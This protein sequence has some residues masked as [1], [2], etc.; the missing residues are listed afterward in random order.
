MESRVKGVVSA[1]ETG[2]D[3]VLM[4]G[5]KGMGGAGKTTLARA[6]FDHISIQFDGQS[7]VENVREVSKASLSG[8]KKLQKQVLSDVLNEKG[9]KVSNVHEGKKMMKNKMRARKVLVVLDDVDNIEQ[10]E[11]LAGE[12]N[13]FKPGSRI[14]ITTRDEQVLVSHRVYLIRD[15]NLLLDDEAVCLFSRYAFGKEIPIQGYEELSRQVVGYASGLPLTI[16]VLG[17]FLCGKDEPEWEDAIDRLKTIPLRETLEKLELSYISLEEDY[18]EIFLDV[19]C[20]LKGWRKDKA[21]EVL[22]S[23]GFHARN[24]L[25]V[26][27]QKS[28]ITTKYGYL[29]MHDHIEEMGKNIVRRLHPSEPSRHSRLWIQEEIADILANDLGTEATRCITLKMTTKNFCVETFIKGLGKMKNLRVLDMDM[30]GSGD[31]RE[32][33]MVMYGSGYGTNAREVPGLCLPNALR[34]FRWDLYPFESLMKSFQEDHLV[35]LFLFECE[36]KQF[37]NC[38]ERKVELSYALTSLMIPNIETIS[39]KE[40]YSFGEL[41]MPFEC[42]KLKTINLEYCSELR[43]LKLAPTPNLETLILAGCHNLLEL[44]T[45]FRCPKLK[46]LDLS[47]CEILRTLK[48]APTP[49]LEKFILAGCHNLLE[50]H[51][52][53]RCPKL[54]AL[55][56]NCSKLWTLEF[57]PTLDI[58]TL[59]IQEPD[60][61]ELHMPNECPN[62][63]SLSVNSSKLR[64]LKLG[65]TP[66]LETL[67]LVRCP[68]LTE[69]H[70]PF[71]CPKLKA[72]NLNC[73]KLRTLE[74]CPTLDIETLSIQEPDLLELHMPN[75][76]SLKSLNVNYSKLRTLNLGSAPDLETLSLEG[77]HSLLELHIPICCPK[78]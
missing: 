14:I 31:P 53:F 54:K 40:C 27:E 1:L 78:L 55:D 57:C 69:V 5:I 23:C 25:R 65:S 59:S 10:L 77:C 66:N 8:L 61:L 74:F 16:R 2:S 64:T 21:V 3:D 49:N 38:G 76:P 75:C 30:S 13:W 26:L 36:F 12:P 60:L 68:D 22:E 71:R 20:I 11:A 6:V 67:S 58:E 9:I 43:T 39:L 56:L 4:I 46:T 72:L 42:S 44:H 51:M 33:D 18:K 32:I 70:M 34:Y 15:A 73:S 7:F 50:L 19:A 41:N 63:K 37:W 35:G 45:P 17:S 28:L 24:G 29:G 48:L 62:L 47:D 52:P